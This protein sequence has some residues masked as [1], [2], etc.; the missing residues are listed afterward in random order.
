MSRKQSQGLLV[1]GGLI[2]LIGV[3]G[4]RLYVVRELLAAF[5]IFC[6]LL[7][8]FGISILASFILGKGIVRSFELLMGR[9]D[10]FHHRQS[11]RSVVGPSRVELA[12]TR[13]QF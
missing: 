3:A 10:S 7:S 12:R 8:A 13:Q 2:T 1:A 9:A 6:A 11:V 4:T 5:L